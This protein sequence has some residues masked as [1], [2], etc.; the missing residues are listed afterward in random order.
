MNSGRKQKFLSMNNF[1]IDHISL[2]VLKGLKANCLNV[3]FQ[4]IFLS[5]APFLSY[6]DTDVF[7]VKLLDLILA[8]LFAFK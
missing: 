6:S 2:F 8:E 3:V 4:K 1:E 5:L 7:H